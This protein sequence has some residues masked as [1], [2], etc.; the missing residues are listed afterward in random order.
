MALPRD[1][2]ANLVVRQAQ[3]IDPGT[4]DGFHA[5]RNSTHAEIAARNPANSNS[6][7]IYNFGINAIDRL[8]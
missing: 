5:D 1:P 3:G 8:I 2:A 4:A 6:I 7:W